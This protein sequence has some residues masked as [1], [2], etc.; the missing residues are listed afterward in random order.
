MNLFP[1][2]GHVRNFPHREFSRGFLII[3]LYGISIQM[4]IQTPDRLLLLFQLIVAY[5]VVTNLLEVSNIA[6]HIVTQSTIA[7]NGPHSAAR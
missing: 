6:L 7:E 1:N 2:I 3:I 4:N 5:N